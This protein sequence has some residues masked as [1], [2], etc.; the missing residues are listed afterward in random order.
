MKGKRQGGGRFRRVHDD[1]RSLP[2]N[3]PGRWDGRRC[4][5]D[6]KILAHIL[7]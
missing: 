6:G 5:Q 4:G 3:L 2:V 1:K 7:G